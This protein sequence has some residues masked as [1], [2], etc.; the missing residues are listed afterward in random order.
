MVEHEVAAI[1]ELARVYHEHVKEN[2]RSSRPRDLH[3]KPLSQVQVFV[4]K[5]D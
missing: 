5:S 2:G 1:V 4:F 3:E